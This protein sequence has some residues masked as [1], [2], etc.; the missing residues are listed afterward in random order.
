MGSAI[1]APLVAAG[2]SVWILRRFGTSWRLAG[3]VTAVVLG[4]FVVLVT[5]GPSLAQGL[6]S[7]VIRPLWLLS[8]PWSGALAWWFARQR[9]AEPLEVGALGVGGGAVIGG[10]VTL[11]TIL[12]GVALVSVPNNFD[13]LAYHL[14]RV[15]HWLQNRAVDHFP[16]H[17]QRQIEQPP[18]TGFAL[19][20][21]RLLAGIPLY[22]LPQAV[23]LIGSAVVASYLAA[24]LGAKPRGQAYAACFVATLPIAVLQ[25]T[26]P[27]VDCVAAFW[28]AT[29]VALGLLLRAPSNGAALPALCGAAL[30]LACLTKGT[31]YVL[32]APFVVW[33]AWREVRAR[34]AGLQRLALAFTVAALAIGAGHHIRNQLASGSPVGPGTVLW[35]GQE[36]T[37]ANDSLGIVPTLSNLMRGAALHLALPDYGAPTGVPSID[38]HV[39]RA[40]RFV[41][42]PQHSTL[43]DKFVS[44]T[45]RRLHE[46]LGWDPDDPATTFHH[47]RFSMSPFRWNSEVGAGN[48]L[49]VAILLAAI[50]T[51]GISRGAPRRF[52][53]VYLGA[54]LASLVLFSAVFKFQPF[55]TR[56]HLPLLVLSGAAVGLALERWPRPLGATAAAL[57][58]LC[59]LP[60]VVNPRFRPLLGPESIF[61]APPEQQLFRMQPYLEAK[62]ERI[63]EA[64]VE[65]GCT[66]VGI[67]VDA[68]SLEQALWITL[69]KHDAGA[70]LHHIGV[71][72]YTRELANG[73]AAHDSVPCFIARIDAT[74]PEV[75][76]SRKS[77]SPYPAYAR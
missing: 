64:V 52:A 10:V 1:L 47:Y 15:E 2:T 41:G 8:I 32:T 3:I 69:R 76:G 14:P 36:V 31:M 67:V 55:H 22:N 30:G 56:L 61:V 70:R 42:L 21:L 11:L 7:R 60:F 63:A 4:T 29:F 25:S 48:P 54:A 73:T 45:V 50:A 57:L 12:V 26:T 34:Q 9:P 27:Q 28:L 74:S 6:T 72:N 59:S 13:A 20:H 23:A 53:A 39:L 40:A 68:S 17:I 49:H 18:W 71:E 66:D 51:L 62:Y 43:R 5:E 33:F 75:R 24:L 16:T 44:R 38:E 58:L 77:E 19:L 46:H 65:S 37:Y 35:R